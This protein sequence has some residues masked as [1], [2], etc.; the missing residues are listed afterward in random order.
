MKDERISAIGY[1]IAAA[2]FYATNVPCA[3]LLLARVPRSAWRGCCMSARGSAWGFSAKATTG[4]ATSSGDK[5]RPVLADR[6][7]NGRLG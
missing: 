5:R 2:A 6:G 7:R 3:K 1:A 4:T